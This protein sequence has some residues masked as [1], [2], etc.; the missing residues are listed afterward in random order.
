MV[1]A[2]G[3]GLTLVSS[4]GVAE[5]SYGV[6]ALVA[7]DEVAPRHHDF[8]EVHSGLDGELGGREH[9]AVGDVPH[10]EAVVEHLA[11][12]LVGG[13]HIDWYGSVE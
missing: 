2:V 11:E 13:V 10:A 6:L 8:L 12:G 7:Y 9:I 4:S 5:L 3:S 1:V